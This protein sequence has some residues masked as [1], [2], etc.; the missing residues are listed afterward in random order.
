MFFTGKV[1]RRFLL[2]VLATTWPTKFSGRCTETAVAEA[3]SFRKVNTTTRNFNFQAYSSCKSKSW[4]TN[5]SL[6]SYTSNIPSKLL[7]Q[8]SCRPPKQRVW[9]REYPYSHRCSS[10]EL[11]PVSRR[12]ERMRQVSFQRLKLIFDTSNLHQLET[13]PPLPLLRISNTTCLISTARSGC[14]LRSSPGLQFKV[15]MEI[16]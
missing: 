4:I 10:S 13:L 3:V 1:G 8:G 14:P 16:Q 6:S 2:K 5:S 12:E 7:R 11:L 9:R 15:F